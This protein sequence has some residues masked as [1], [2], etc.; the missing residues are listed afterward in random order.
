MQKLNRKKSKHTTTETIKSQ[1]KRLRKG[2]KEFLRQPENN[3][4]KSN[5]YIFI[6]NYFKCKRTKFFNQKDIE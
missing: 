1:R 3:S 4:Q 6:N 5:K 2:G